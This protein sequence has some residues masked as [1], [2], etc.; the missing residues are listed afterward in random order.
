MMLREK[1]EF[2]S[3]QSCIPSPQLSPFAILRAFQVSLV[4]GMCPKKSGNSWYSNGVSAPDCDRCVEETCF[5]KRFSR[6]R[7]M[8]EFKFDWPSPHITEL[9]MQSTVRGAANHVPVRM[10]CLVTVIF[11]SL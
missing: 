4:Q 3:V 9:D 8:R 1:T 11:S 6:S 7:K 10:H 2:L 5:S